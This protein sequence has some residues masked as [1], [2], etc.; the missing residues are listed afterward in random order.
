MTVS[1]HSI[2]VPVF[3][4]MLKSLDHILVQAAKHTDEKKIDPTVLLGCRLSPSMFNLTRQVQVT[5]DFAK[6]TTARLA[7]VEIPAM[8]DV[9]T[10]F[11]ELRARIARTIAF[12]ESIKP[13]QI[14]GAEDRDIT[15]PVRGQS[16]TLKG[17]VYLQNF[18][19]PN[20]YF[21]HVA[22]YAILRHNGVDLSKGDYLG[23][24]QTS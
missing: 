7:G 18:G 14:N 16:M 22:A 8:A 15:F 24:N 20:F 1:V 3:V 17:L 2:S 6:N 11:E 19:M 21:H 10:S 5:C 12:V 4:H 9:E 13:E 23:W